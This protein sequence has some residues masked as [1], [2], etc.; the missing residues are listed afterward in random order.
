MSL[1]KKMREITEQFM[2]EIFAE[3]NCPVVIYD[4]KGYIIQAIDESR[5]GHLHPGAKKIMDGLSNEYAV[6][7]SEAKES[8]L[9]KEGYSCPIVFE[10]EK[11]GGFGITGP[12]NIA[13]PIAR[14][15]SKTIK[16]WLTD[17]KHQEKLERSEKKYRTL[18]NSSIDAISI[19]DLT[20][21][22]FVDCNN[23][24]IDLHDTESRE[25]FLGTTPGELSPE[26]QPNGQSSKKL[27]S[28]QIQNAFK[29]GGRS[30]EWTHCKRDGTPFPAVITLSPLVIGEKKFVLAIARDITHRR[31]AEEAR[32]QLIKSLH[33][34][35]EKVK[36]LS[37]LV[38]ICSKC[39]KIRD[40]KG[41]WNQ[42]EVHIQNH[43]YAK[44]SHGICPEC[45]DELYGKKEWYIKMKK[46]NSKASVFK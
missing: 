31:Q 30:F 14:V 22:R 26:Y 41:Y 9:V 7:S 6:T 20:T 2:T 32:E 24:A 4:N 35:L 33:E 13:K 29:G 27:A 43:T 34:A 36:T 39:K 42:V 10:G 5:I 15:A 21:E 25:N 16:S 40:D 17:I 12:L 38:P 8:P 45:S 28:E 11:I 37:G 46:K 1:S 3:T 23:A 18:F 19:L 44:F